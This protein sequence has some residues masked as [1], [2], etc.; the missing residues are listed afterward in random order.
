MKIG[1]S[2]VGAPAV[3]DLNPDGRAFIMYYSDD[4]GLFPPT[5]KCDAFPFYDVY[6]K[7][8][9]CELVGFGNAE[10]L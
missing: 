8:F 7:D 10:F 1:I 5:N 9:C 3:D 2:W 4:S 6:P